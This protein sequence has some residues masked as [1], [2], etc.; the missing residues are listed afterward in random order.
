MAAKARANPAA[1]A[2]PESRASRFMRSALAILAETGRTDF[3]VLEV[4]ERSKTSLRAFYQHFATKDELLL[5]VVAKIMS[6]ATEQWRIETEPLSS[7][8]ALRRVIGRIS[9][10]AKSSAQDSINRGL[11][12]YNDHLL[13]S[14][15]K[16]FANVLR[17]LHLL[18]ADIL[19]RGI[20]EGDFR[21]DLD[22]DTDA[23]ILMQ[24]ALGAL[25]LRELGAELNGVPIG[26]A[27]MYEFY[28]RGLAH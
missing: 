25:R 10:P 19:R 28:M 13:E 17:P 23:A 7:P 24:T 11:T 22:V 18:F 14:R 5:A 1:G 6:D 9:A 15:P 20:A 4:V 12:Y 16:E 21:E 26:G 8:D 3:T 2:E 27:H